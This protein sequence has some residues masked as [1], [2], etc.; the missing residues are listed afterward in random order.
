MTEVTALLLLTLLFMS[1]L[2]LTLLF[3]VIV[4][5]VTNVDVIIFCC[6]L[7]LGCVVVYFESFIG[8]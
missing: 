6:I 8:M 4:Y 7:I 3:S 1:M 5:M 2:L